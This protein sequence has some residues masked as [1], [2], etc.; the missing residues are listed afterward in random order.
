M[1]KPTPQHPSPRFAPWR[2]YPVLAA[3]TQNARAKFVRDIGNAQGMATA[4]LSVTVG[5]AGVPAGETL[6]CEIAQNGAQAL[7]GV[8]DSK[9]NRWKL[10]GRNVTSRGATI[11]YCYVTVALT[12][13]DTVT[14]TSV[15]GPVTFGLTQFTGLVNPVVDL[16]ASGSA[17]SQSV[18]VGPSGSTGTQDGVA[19]GVAA[20]TGTT[21][22][23]NPGPGWTMLATPASTC[24][25]EYRIVQA[26]ETETLAAQLGSSLA[27]DGLVV[28]LTSGGADPPGLAP[29]PQHPSPRFRPWA[30]AARPT[31]AA[32]PSLTTTIAASA[33]PSGEAFGNPTVGAQDTAASI[34]SAESFGT[35]RVQRV[36]RATTIAT[37]EA[38]GKPALIRSAAATSITSAESFG[39]PTAQRTLRS[40]GVATSESFGTPAATRVLTATTIGTGE[41]FGTDTVARTI[42]AQ[43]IASGEQ[44]GQPRIIPGAAPFSG[45]IA[46]TSI[47]SSESFGSPTVTLATQTGGP[48]LQQ[49]INY[50][51]R[52]AKPET[53]PLTRSTR[54]LCLSS[55]EQVSS[56]G[57]PA[58][59]ISPPD[60]AQPR[61][62]EP[63]HEGPDGDTLLLMGVL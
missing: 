11:Y 57:T 56:F 19:I 58:V 52:P 3:A 8:T 59:D 15:A 48:G 46:A 32:I 22:W 30:R 9:G 54:T 62:A 12:S 24:G 37:S 5:G 13:S 1:Q 43:T 63:I 45:V 4:G 2:L 42:G 21:T 36:A 14:V 27:Y 51:R 23:T 55:I 25:R 29:A 35:A 60:I 18:T 38:F 39:R 50:V 53:P 34:P 33:I 26:R 31:P 17:T 44:V 6:T 28:V 61:T 41:T 20:W 47:S 7:V 49:G 10:A 40:A 16:V